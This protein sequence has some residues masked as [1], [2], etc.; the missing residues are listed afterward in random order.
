MGIRA[1][2][3][4]LGLVIVLSSTSIS[5]AGD[6]DFARAAA[7][8]A[9][10][11]AADPELS[12]K[13][14]L[15]RFKAA[16]VE[17]EALILDPGPSAS[18]SSIRWEWGMLLQAK[19]MFVSQLDPELAASL[20]SA[21]IDAMK[22]AIVQFTA[23]G[24]ALDQER[25]AMPV[26]GKSGAAGRMLDWKTRQARFYVCTANYQLALLMDEGGTMR[27]DQAKVAGQQLQDFLWDNE[28]NILGGYSYIYLGL[29]EKVLGHPD[30]ALEFL[31]AVS[32]GYPV[33]NQADADNYRNW[34]DL[35]LQGYFKIGEYCNELGKRDGKDYR[36]VALEILKTMP[37]RVPDLWQRKFGHL[38]LIEQA[39]ALKDLGRA[40]E[41]RILLE[42]IV[43]ESK[44]LPADALWGSATAFVAEQILAQK[45]LELPGEDEEP[46]DD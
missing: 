26:A 23:V 3:A 18:L 38:A 17:F 33:P 27:E 43:K 30:Q 36:E 1:T 16:E 37:K 39:R 44:N 7:S 34:T 46:S 12:T 11:A 42:R 2:L 32:S 21:G 4:V 9:E 45:E 41:A 24:N 10:A 5:L 40:A 31:Q 25:K 22:G 29:S 19:G 28:D 20:G 35:F 6:L 15:L 8:A 13:D 14:V